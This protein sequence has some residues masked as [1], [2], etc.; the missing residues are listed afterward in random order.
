MEE[1]NFYLTKEGLKKLEKEYRDLKKL[2][3]L[4]IKG[5]SPKFLKSEDFNPEYFSF[6]EN[7]SFLESRIVELENIFK[8]FKLIKTP[9]KGKQG[10]VNLG[11]TV[12]VEVDGRTDKFKIVGPLEANPSLGKISNESPVGR[13]LLGHRVGEEVIV[14]SPIKIVY[15]IKKITYLS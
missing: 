11:A 15:K 6:W 7:L 4:K 9:P 8:N 14:S 5:E 3:L 13:T 1:K 12:L 2:R 10:V